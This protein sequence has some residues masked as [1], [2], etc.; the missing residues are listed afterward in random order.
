M[1]LAQRTVHFVAGMKLE[2]AKINP[3]PERLRALRTPEG[4]GSFG[5]VLEIIHLIKEPTLLDK[6]ASAAKARAEAQRRTLKD[7]IAHARYGDASD[8][9][10][11]TRDLSKEDWEAMLQAVNQKKALTNDTSSGK[12]MKAR[13]D[14]LV[15]LIEHARE[16]GNKVSVDE[17]ANI[18]SRQTVGDT[19][20]RL[21]SATGFSFRFRA[22]YRGVRGSSEDQHYYFT[23]A[24]PRGDE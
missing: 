23:R 22:F 24:A 21:R 2:H 9:A 20:A 18:T 19:D 6:I 14:D 11:E 1:L 15:S 17:L 5:E 3:V 16:H 8:G 7:A 13:L 4:T 10:K 12:R